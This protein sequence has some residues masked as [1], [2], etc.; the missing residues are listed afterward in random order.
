[1][2][3]S[4]LDLKLEAMRYGE[5]LEFFE[6]FLIFAF[7]VERNRNERMKVLEVMGPKV[8]EA[9]RKQNKERQRGGFQR[10]L[11]CPYC[12]EDVQ[13]VKCLLD[14]GEGVLRGRCPYCR[15]RMEVKV[16]GRL[17]GCKYTPLSHGG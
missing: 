12:K 6:E 10:G 14:A 1:M 2:V 4:H 15:G 9:F 11:E 3:K 7:E 16:E 8:L 13:E 5:F 17:V